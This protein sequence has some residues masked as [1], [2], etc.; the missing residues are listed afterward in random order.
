MLRVGEGVL[1]GNFHIGNSQLGLHRAVH[2][3]HHTMD[4]GL[5][6]DQNIHLVRFQVEQPPGLDHF[7]PLVHH[8]GRID[9]D[10]GPHVP[11]GMSQGLSLGRLG[12][13]LP[14]PRSERPA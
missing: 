1:D 3:L 7:Q 14:R 8:G 2:E 9:G 13:L 4:D 5:R 6:M 11:V 12:K 10:L